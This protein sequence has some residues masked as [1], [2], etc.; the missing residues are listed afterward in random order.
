M[1]GARKPVIKTVIFDLGN[2]LLR[3]DA[4]KAALRFARECGI[5]LTRLW[6]HFFISSVEKAYT[7]GEISSLEF[8]RHAKKVLG[9]KVGFRTFK[10]YWNDIFLESEGMEALLCDL[11]RR[12][13]LY[14]ISNTNK[15][16]FEHIKKNYSL[17]R[18]FKR[19]FPSH[20]VGAR[21]PERAI[22]ETVLKTLGLNPAETVFIDDMPA[23]VRGARHAG[24]HAIRFRSKNQLLKDLRKLGVKI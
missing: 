21:K 13:P 2:V 15:L 6:K 10:H 5:P 11:K 23:F 4:R 18:H 9:F 7:R 17:L 16:H 24:M 3:Y 8:F 14:L 12:Y 1:P 20:E 19:T 22:Y